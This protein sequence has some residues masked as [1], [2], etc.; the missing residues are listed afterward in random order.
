MIDTEQRN[1]LENF[2]NCGILELITRDCTVF[3]NTKRHIKKMSFNDKDVLD[4]GFVPLKRKGT[5]PTSLNTR[6]EVNLQRSMSFAVSTGEKVDEQTIWDSSPWSK[7]ERSKGKTMD[8]S[9]SFVL[10]SETRS[11]TTSTSLVSPKKLGFP[12][13]D[14]KFNGIYNNHPLYGPSLAK[15][16][17]DYKDPDCPGV[18]AVVDPFSTGAHLAT[19]ITKAGLKCA[20]IFSIWDSPV[21]GL[22]QQGIV[23]EYCA[24]IQHKNT[25][26]D[27]D[28]AINDTIKSLNA[29]P[30]KIIAVVAG[31]E[32]GVEL[33]DALSHRMGLRSNGEEGGLARRNKFL[34]GEKVRN[35]GVR[36]VKQ[37]NCTSIS[38]LRNFLDTLTTKPFKCVVKPVQSA[39]SD[40]VFLCSSYEEA[41]TAFTRIYGK[42]NGLGLVNE[43]ALA[44]EFLA[45]KE[46]VVDKVSV[47]GVHKTV[48]IWEYD[49]RPVNGASF[50]YF[51]MR[52]RPSHTEKAKTLMAYADQCLD[53]L[54]ILEG[55][56]HMEVMWCSDGPCLVEVGARCQGGEGTWLPVAKECVGYTQ[57]ELCLDAYLGGHGIFQDVSSSSFPMMKYGRDVDMVNRHGGIIRALKGEKKIKALESF[58]FL[59]WE[60]KVGDYAPA[61]IDCFTRPGCAQFVNE[62][63][64]QVDADMEALHDMEDY[65]LLDYSVI[66]PKPPS[67]GSVVVVDAFSTGSNLAAMLTDW[68]YKLILVFSQKQTNSDSD[69]ESQSQMSPLVTKNENDNTFII[70]HDN[71]SSDQDSAV[72]ATLSEI[73][74]CDSPVLAIIPGTM[75]GVNLADILSSR[76][77]TRSNGESDI[78]K[79]TNK[80]LM[81]IALKESGK[82]LRYMEQSLCMSLSDIEANYDIMS[83]SSNNKCKC[84]VKAN[85]SIGSDNVYVCSSLDEAKKAFNSINGQVNSF[86]EVLTGALIQKFLD[87]AVYAV[88]GVSRDGE[89]KVTAIWR[90]DKRR[91]NNTDFVSFGAH[92]CDGNGIKEQKI[93]QYAKNV[94]K[95]LSINQGPSHME[96]MWNDESPVLLDVNARIHG[97]NGTWIP[98]ADQCIGYTQVDAT[99]NCY[100]RPDKYDELP[101]FPTLKKRGCEAFLVAL[102]D[103]TGENGK[104]LKSISG[105]DEIANFSSFCRME[106]ITQPGNNVPPTI[107]SFT[108]IGSVQ[109]VNESPASLVEDYERIRA[110]EC[111]GLLSF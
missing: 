58:R 15:L 84:I 22:I 82:G 23:A 72:A 77:Q 65:D 21:A 107:D 105:V 70:Q 104:I 89:Y 87:G 35:A 68:G 28:V 27:Q 110:L 108:R 106:L 101:M 25:M 96:L 13:E 31:A 91:T 40:D 85:S 63:E 10:T 34:M 61:T 49:K 17:F 50:V 94:N 44:Q 18:I 111:D 54:G 6:S 36:A 59:S 11:R 2:W 76:F 67:I 1:I 3:E 8:R 92:L 45:G 99:L 102:E 37:R 4:A 88:D 79:R 98:V 97:G 48:A 66:C 78:E 69:S 16:P 73:K 93:I 71:S 46:F 109:L 60:V 32:T 9:N 81:Q 64:E 74:K 43:S 19:E 38:D 29:L 95:A 5:E 14:N 83:T 33:A 42:I 62:N 47:G 103:V 12:N 39:G 86:G 75:T 26:E 90:Y 24:T 100:L 80:Y 51:G 20:R 30:F 7:M 41:E 57:V 52:L 56:S 53:A 55:P